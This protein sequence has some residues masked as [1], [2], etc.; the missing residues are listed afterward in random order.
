MK[1]RVN[2]A[3]KNN[4]T[5]VLNTIQRTV[6]IQEDQQPSI[7]GFADWIGNV[8]ASSDLWRTISCKHAD[9]RPPLI[10]DGKQAK[11]HHGNNLVD[12]KKWF[13]ELIEREP[14]LASLQL[15]LVNVADYK[16]AAPEE[17]KILLETL[18]C[19]KDPKQRADKVIFTYEIHDGD[20][21]S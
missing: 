13:Q 12:M 20:I 4:L 1:I 10:T 6:G 15:T 19:K 18:E 5:Q 16:K 14:E 9:I 2:L 3:G 17:Y 11:D 7:D 21:S 8:A